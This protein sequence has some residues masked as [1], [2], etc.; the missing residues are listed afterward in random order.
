M[1]APVMKSLPQSIEAEQSVLGAMIID[2]TTIA[3]ADEVNKKE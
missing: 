3:Q 1:E 2:R